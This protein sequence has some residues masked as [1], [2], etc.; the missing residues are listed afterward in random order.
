MSALKGLEPSTSRENSGQLPKVFQCA[1]CHQKFSTRVRKL[2]FK[3]VLAK[4]SNFQVRPILSRRRLHDVCIRKG[5]SQAQLRPSAFDQSKSKPKPWT[6]DYSKNQ[7]H[8]ASRNHLEKKV[9]RSYGTRQESWNNRGIFSI[10][11]FFLILVNF[12]EN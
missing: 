7:I 10:F 3:K 6:R 1:E 2:F 12:K 4:S 9:R 5:G 11:L 8:P